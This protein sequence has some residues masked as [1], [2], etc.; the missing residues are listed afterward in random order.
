MTTE[1]VIAVAVI[2][3]VGF[4]TIV[5]IGVAIVFD[6]GVRAIVAFFVACGFGG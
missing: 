1:F 4:P 6:N 5:A 3:V 2:V